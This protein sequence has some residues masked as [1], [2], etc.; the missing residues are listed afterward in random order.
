LTHNG[1][2][3]AC[4]SDLE[5]IPDL[6]AEWSVISDTLF[7]F[8]LHEGIFFHNGEEMTAYDVVASLEYVRTYPYARAVHASIVGWEAIDRYTFILDTGEPNAQLLNDLTHQANFIMPRS[9]IE[10]GHDFTTSPIGSGPFVFEEW[11]FGDSLD[12]SRFDD[13]FDGMPYPDIR[14]H[15]ST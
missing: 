9:L 7:E 2:F 5:P 3:R 12:F 8:T 1:L 13:Y 11:R 15:R 6:V 14:V 10:A 4:Y